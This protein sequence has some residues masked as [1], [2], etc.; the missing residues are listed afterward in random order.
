MDFKDAEEQ[1]L[2]AC[3]VEKGLQNSSVESYRE[4]LDLFAA[5]LKEE[6]PVEELTKKDI[7]AFI[8][9]MLSEG[10]AVSTALR[11]A[12]TVRSFF[13]FLQK[14]GR[15]DSTA[16]SVDLPKMPKHL[17][18]VLSFEEVDEL[19]AQPDMEKQS[20]I[21]DRA[22]LEVLYACG[23]RISELLALEKKNVSLEKGVIRVF[24]KGAKERFVPISDFALEY[25]LKYINE[26]RSL[27]K[28]RNS[29]YIFINDDGKPF[30]RQFFWKRIKKYSASAGIIVN[31][32]PHTLRHCFATHL[33]ENGADLRAV[34][35]MLG[36]S[37][38]TT[39]QIYTH[40]SSR[41]IRS[42]YDLFMR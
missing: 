37:N 29:R 20:G 18:T 9:D 39:T 17:P 13:L 33:L 38:I 27:S 34:Q 5:S 28:H 21:R 23:L 24:G 26:V 8:N 11:R 36:H 30:T 19:L 42:A 12:S 4:D 40:V 10:K 41:R 35:E 2:I 31:V 14:L 15:M 25:L 6:K 7:E 1:F 22:M 32:T 3:I 16:A